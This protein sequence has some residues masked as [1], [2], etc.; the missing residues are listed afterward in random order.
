VESTVDQLEEVVSR[1]MSNES[2][3]EEIGNQGKQFAAKFHDGS[4]SGAVLK[5][6]ISPGV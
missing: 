6:W 5:S 3:R 1:F 4:Y 2:A